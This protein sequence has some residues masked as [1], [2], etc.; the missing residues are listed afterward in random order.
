M[1]VTASQLGAQLQAY[2]RDGL[3]SGDKTGW[4]SVDDFYTVRPGQMTI[5][6]GIPSHGKSEWLDALMVNL[7][8]QWRFVVFSPENYPHELHVAKLLEKWLRA[9]FAKGPHPR[10]TPDKLALGVEALDFSFGFFKPLELQVPN[11]HAI[12]NESGK[13]FESRLTPQKRGLVIDPFNELEHQ[14]PANITETEYISQFLSEIRQWA[15]EFETHVWI[16]AHPM[17]LQKDKSTGDYPVP[18]PYD[19]SGSAHWRNKA[20]N[21]ITVWRDVKKDNGIVEIHVQKVRFKNI[22]KPGRIELRYDRV[23]GRYS[24]MPKA[25]DVSNYRQAS[26]GDD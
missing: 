12:L 16:V 17:K 11:L 3:P 26:G 13:W 20:D 6:T 10:I 19:I 24:E 14:R 21:C 9:P 15:R 23:T 25:V 7:A 5:V 2:Y 4:Q 18:T 22:G 8:P 1:I